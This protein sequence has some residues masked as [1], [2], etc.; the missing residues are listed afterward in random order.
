MRRLISI[1]VV[2]LVTFAGT[3]AQAPS[4]SVAGEVLDAATGA[5]IGGATLTLSG[6]MALA[7]VTDDR[8]KFRFDRVPIGVYT[9]LRSTAQG[10]AAGSYGATTS[11]W[12][13]GSIALTSGMKLAGLT[14]SLW[15]LAKISGTVR[16]DT[17][18]PL[19]NISVR[20][21]S[22][23]TTAGVRR[24]R[25]DPNANKAVTDSHG[26]YTL[27]NLP[28]GDYLVQALAA[29]APQLPRLDGRAFPT[30]IYPSASTPSQAGTITLDGRN[31]RASVDLRL[32]A[33]KPVHVS[34]KLTGPTK[35]MGTIT[36]RLIPAGFDEAADESD[37]EA[38][39]ALT[40]ADGSFSFLGVLP[41]QYTL[42]ALRIAQSR[43]A[44]AGGSFSGFFRL[45]CGIATALTKDD[46]YSGAIV[47]IPTSSEPSWWA[48]MPIAVGESDV[49]DVNVT[50]Q[51]G[52][53]LSGRVEFDGASPKPAAQVM[54]QI[55]LGLEPADGR[56]LPGY[57]LTTLGRI[58]ADGTFSSVGYPAGRYLFRVARLPADWALSAIRMGSQDVS[59]EPF[60]LT[61]DITGLTIVLT[62]HPNELSG[63]V[64]AE[65][66]TLDPSTSV[67]VFPV[68]QRAWVG[69]GC[70]PRGL[71][72]A[73][74]SSTGTYAFSS[75]PPG[76]Y[77]V[78]AVSD[79]KL[80]DWRTPDFLST[81]VGQSKRITIRA[82][83]QVL[84][85][86]VSPLPGKPRT[87]RLASPG[88][89]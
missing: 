75:L 80:D 64:R 44:P 25:P 52:A 32:S 74:V 60:T 56:R 19:A 13:V 28:P 79:V 29:V 16:D 22:W 55:A 40:E 85:D 26:S 69:N 86:L 37:F 17:D 7:T 14:I 68:N 21:L 61:G 54:M 84:Q 30:L 53:R 33:A 12:V 45:G 50:A 4:A 2:V 81:V 47:A 59:D 48:E 36:V 51:S 67:I 87:S 11:G 63:S 24:L 72:S 71:Q 41:G 70:N 73:H 27:P 3:G 35:S 10:Y 78:V 23:I 9:S 49:T 76:D 31:D 62:D 88:R 38:A 5:P 42:T 1:A 34:G 57:P 82:G 20:A 6:E 15:K 8:G 66:G 18:E 89:S 77:Y 43:P 46:T 39:R 58:E 83:A 65:R